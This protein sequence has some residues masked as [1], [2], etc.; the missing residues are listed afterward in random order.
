MLQP[1]ATVLRVA[2]VAGVREGGIGQREDQAAV[3]DVVAVEHR[4]A[5]RHAHHGAARLAADQLDV[6]EIPGGAVGGEH[7][8]ADAGGQRA[9]VHHSP[10]N[11]AG[12]FS[13]NAIT[14]SM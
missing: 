3:A 4:L 10:L 6:H 5:H 2:A 1:A 12:R 11:C 13:R 8:L 7:R 9:F 14:P